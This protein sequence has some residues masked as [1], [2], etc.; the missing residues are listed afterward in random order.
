MTEE[1]IKLALFACL[2]RH[3]GQ[4]VIKFDGF[5]LDVEVETKSRGLVMQLEL[6]ANMS[7]TD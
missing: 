3:F 7:Y 6:E 2:G 4:L 5:G 1:V